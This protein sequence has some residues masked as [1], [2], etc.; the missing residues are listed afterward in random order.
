M[1][2]IHVIHRQG[3]IH[4]SVIILRL[5]EYIAKSESSILMGSV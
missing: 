3:L 5:Y 1:N 4:I 2:V